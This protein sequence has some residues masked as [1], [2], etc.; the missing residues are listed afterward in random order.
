MQLHWF[1]D[2]VW[3]YQMRSLPLAELSASGSGLLAGLIHA[4]LVSR[5]PHWRPLMLGLLLV[6]LAVPYIKPLI[7]PLEFEE[8][9][10]QCPGGI[11]LQ[12]TPST[13]GPASVA[14][15][16]RSSPVSYVLRKRPVDSLPVPSMAGVVL[17]G[18]FVLR[19]SESAYVVGDPM[20]GAVVVPK[21]AL[22]EFYNSTGFFMVVARPDRSRH[23]WRR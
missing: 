1:D 4:L 17:S 16:L 6:G 18:G 20:V 13:C 19:E 8:L 12:S 22:G 10:A 14:S 3:F 21:S 11:C 23:P 9:T 5:K 2:A 15:I 7:A